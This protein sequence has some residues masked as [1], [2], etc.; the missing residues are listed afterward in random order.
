MSKL[1]GK[2]TGKLTGKFI[3]AIV[4][5][6][7]SSSAFADL[8]ACDIPKN[9]DTDAFAAQ[10]EVSGSKAR[11]TILGETSRCTAREISKHEMD[12][13]EAQFIDYLKE[14]VESRYIEQHQADVL[15]VSFLE[16]K[17]NVIGSIG[18][19]CLAVDSMHGFFLNK[20]KEKVSYFR[21]NGGM[22]N[23]RIPATCELQ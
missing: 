19:E 21:L 1:T 16:I 15:M 17:K 9:Q 22:A 23:L 5:L 3:G 20:T 6:T 4:I 2:F 10:V 11:V 18:V 12:E 7:F 8:Y 14:A 13:E